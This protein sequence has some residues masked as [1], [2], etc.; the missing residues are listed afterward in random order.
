MAKETARFSE[1]IIGKDPWK[2]HADSLLSQSRRLRHIVCLTVDD[3]PTLLIGFA[4]SVGEVSLFA[5]ESMIN[6]LSAI[7]ATF[8]G[9]NVNRFHRKCKKI[10]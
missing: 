5:V 1:E 4:I 10:S 3:L 6:I 2:V 8:V 9:R 7:G